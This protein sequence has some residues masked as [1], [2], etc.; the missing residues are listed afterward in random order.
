M[1]WLLLS[2]LLAAAG[3]AHTSAA[4]NDT[5]R[6]TL[7]DAL[8]LAFRQSPALV[9]S[10]SSRTK[11]GIVLARGI[12]GLIPTVSGSMG[13]A[14]S[15][16]S[17]KWG[18]TGSLTVAQVVFDPE[19]FG[20]IAGSVAYS[21]YYKAEADDKLCRLAYDVTSGYLSLVKA[22]MLA[23]AAEASLARA[24]ENLRVAE[25]RKK[26]GS[27]SRIDL[28]RARAVSSQAE[29]SRLQAQSGIRLAAEQLKALLNLDSDKTIVPADSLTRPS[30]LEFGRPESLIAEIRRRNPGLQL[31]KRSAAA[32]GINCASAIGKALPAVSAYLTSA[33]ADTLFPSSRRVWQDHDQ[34]SVG[35]RLS[36]PLLDLK[37]YALGIAD[38]TNESRRARAAARSALLNLNAAATEAV[39]SYQEARQNL[40]YAGQNLQLNQ[41][42]YDLARQEQQL[43]S[44][45]LFELLSV[46]ADLSRARAAYIGALCDTYIRA[47]QINY[48][49]GSTA[50]S[51]K[52]N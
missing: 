1:C 25:E 42:L 7:D 41:E 22:R 37:S 30:D 6:L 21:G 48:L 3:P 47:A 12:T 39:L 16:P 52:E 31:A 50:L 40:E 23:D 10:Q 20:A 45:S 24:R 18:W 14:K 46:E 13:Y 43:G 29:L 49:L 27:A 26:L 28:L 11:S 51:R 19:A 36:F 35:L 9:Q 32:A 38:A 44:I 5:L 8:R 34:T 4:A 15:D 33:Y 2:V 17:P